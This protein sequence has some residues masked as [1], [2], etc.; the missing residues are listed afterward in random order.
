MRHGIIVVSTTVFCRAWW[1][2]AV[3]VLPKPVKRYQV[4]DE[5]MTM[6]GIDRI[7]IHVAEIPQ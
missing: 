6:S 3:P 4:N 1:A 2:V 5:A 7:R